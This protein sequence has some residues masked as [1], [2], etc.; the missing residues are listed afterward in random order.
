MLATI[1]DPLVCFWGPPG[2]TIQPLLCRDVNI[3]LMTLSF[4]IPIDV[5]PSFLITTH[6]APAPIVLYSIEHQGEEK[7]NGVP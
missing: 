3:C 4:G 1:M 2:S 5:A 6:L 7:H